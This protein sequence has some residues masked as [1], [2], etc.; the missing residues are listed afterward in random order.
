[1]PSLARYCL[2]LIVLMFSPWVLAATADSEAPTMTWQVLDFQRKST[3]G[4]AN[5]R[6]TLSRIA[7]AGLDT[8]LRQPGARSYLQ[9]NPTRSVQE[10][11]VEATVG[12]KNQVSLQLLMH[13]ETQAL[14][15]RSRFSI[16]RKDRRFKFFR[17]AEDGLTRQ[18]RDPADKKEAKLPEQQWSR[19][20]STEV[21]YPQELQNTAV[22]SPFAL[23][24]VLSRL[25]PEQLE[26]QPTLLVNT[27]TNVYKVT[28]SPQPAQQL[29]VDYTLERSGQTAQR[30]QETINAIPVK[31]VVTP[32]ALTSNK[33]D[34]ELM[35]LSGEITVFIDGLDHTP[36]R[37][38]GIAPRVGAAHL[39]IA[40]VV[41]AE[42]QGPAD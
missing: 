7:A 6:L 34:F 5:S 27:D 32:T 4:D 16:G 38:A 33:P 41:L 14:Y 35:G 39:D 37:V 30:R 13:P 31:L 10:L 22:T 2:P 23:F 17:Y 20:S 36:L 18:R 29:D 26:Q 3:W 1:M 21:N 42:R 9:P 8:V 19:S 15:Q 40:N 12:T 28:L 11:Q 25:S 24:V